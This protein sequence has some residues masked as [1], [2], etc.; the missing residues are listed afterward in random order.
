MKKIIIILAIAGVAFTIHSCKKNTMEKPVNENDQMLSRSQKVVALIQKFDAKIKGNLKSGEMI[1]AD[2][3]V[4]NMEASLNYN[5]AISD[6]SAANLLV[7]KSFY[8]IDVNAGQMVSM[9]DVTTV[10]GQM[11]DTLNIQYNGITNTV[12]HVAFADVNMDSVVGT[13][14]YLSVT[15]GFGVDLPRTYVP[16]AE[17]DD[18][19]WGTLM[20][21]YGEP[22][23]GKCDGTEVGVS[24]G[25]DELQWRLN[26]PMPVPTQ[27]IFYT[28]LVTLETTGFDFTDEN[29]NARLYVGWDYPQQNCLTNDT[30][31]YYLNQSDDIIYTYD[32][33]GGLRP[34]DKDFVRVKIIDDLLYRSS[35]NYYLHYYFVTYG[36]PCQ[37][38][39]PN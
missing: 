35:G 4:W 24:D 28:D 30:L 21:E 33:D 36:K 14:G 11:D 23:A 26:N 29:V 20:E 2:S 10:Y 27:Q 6:S 18:W 3:A 16:F 9:D 19:I 31:T 34:P 15:T 38:P 13:T 5:Y 32:Y 8:T 7:K 25:S 1:T 39:P 12:K 17:D 37:A 22:P